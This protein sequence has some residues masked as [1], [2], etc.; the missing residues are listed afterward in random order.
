MK[1]ANALRQL[2]STQQKLLRKLLLSPQGATVEELCKALGV[3]H[4]AVRQHLTALMVQGFV[5][6]GE[7]IPSGGRP[8]ACFVLL[9]A[10]RELFPR[11]YAL[12]ADGMLEY[13]YAHAGVAA[14]QALLAD[15]GAKLGEDAA[16]RIATASDTAEA[17]RLLAE[18]LD[19]LGYE[20]E[21]VE[22][23]DHTEVEAWNCVFHSLARTHPDVCRFDLA[24]MSAATGRPVQR[25]QCMLHGA[26]AC[27]FR[28]AAREKTAG[29]AG[30]VVVESQGRKL[31]AR[32]GGPDDR[33][34]VA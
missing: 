34:G 15:M 13:L 19:T 11:N 3:T 27:R 20:A 2:G 9:P 5:A 33:P 26:P 25:T 17:T 29:A 10:G 16:S 1:P 7:S 18:Q 31:L 8:R 30:T 12:I 14:V 22:V 23:G 6:R 21:V 24:F 32:S 4:N 28:I